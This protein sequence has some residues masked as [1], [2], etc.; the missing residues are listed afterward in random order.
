[1]AMAGNHPR[2]AAGKMLKK[3]CLIGLPDTFFLQFRRSMQLRSNMDDNIFKNI[4]TEKN[5][6][7]ITVIGVG[8]TYSMKLLFF[9]EIITSTDL[10]AYIS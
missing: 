3:N 5:T 7:K 8:T 1:M 6:Y 10:T 2:P 9:D 4:N